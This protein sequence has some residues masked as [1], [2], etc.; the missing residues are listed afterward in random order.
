MGRGDGTRAGRATDRTR[1]AIEVD[2]KLHVE[3]IALHHAD[4]FDLLAVDSSGM[5]R[6]GS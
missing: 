5:R 4:A 6:K 2:M 1:R 3:Q